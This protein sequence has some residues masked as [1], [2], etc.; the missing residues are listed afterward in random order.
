MNQDT[1]GILKN[2]QYEHIQGYEYDLE[3]DLMAILNG[4]LKRH[5]DAL[6]IR[7]EDAEAVQEIAQKARE[8]CVKLVTRA[9]QG[10][11]DFKGAD[12]FPNAN[13]LVRD[14]ANYYHQKIWKDNWEKVKKGE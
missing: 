12:N 13:A 6:P 7:E 5:Y 14:T 8:V 4:K 11:L 2:L 3:E 9:T 10:L 1:R